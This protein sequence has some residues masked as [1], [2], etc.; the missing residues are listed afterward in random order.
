MKGL[1]LVLAPLLAL[2]IG[3]A[4]FAAYG[5]NPA[6]AYAAM[7]RA[8]LGSAHGLSECV[9]KATPLIFT[10]L[11][12][13]LPATMQ[14]WNIGAEGQFAW[15]AVAATWVALFAAPLLPGPLVLPAVFLAGAAAGAAWGAIPGALKARLG[16]SEILTTLL[17]NYVAIIAMEH[18]FFGPWRDPNGLGFPG[19]ALFP[20][21]AL[22]PR[23]PGARIH[24][25]LPLSLGL[26]LVLHLVLSRS[27]FGYRVRAMGLAPRAARYAGLDV[28]GHTLLV[29]ALAGGLAGLAGACEVTG[30]HHKLQEGVAVG[31][32][33]DGI[34]AA[35]LAR[36]KPAAVPLAALALGA[37]MVGGEGLQSALGLPASISQVLT[38][39]LLLGLLAADR[40]AARLEAAAAAREAEHAG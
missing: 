5:A 17:L 14:L 25:G 40:L 16:A 18:L 28:A 31:L 15:G 13:A 27:A 8:A 20:D 19:T 33:Y 3:A 34:V 12:V 30:I 4:V 35:C 6:E 32:G 11:A 10:G 7:A 39:S 29:L 9:V 21:A 24:L 36:L 38:A 2:A 22:N 26:A 37:V 23:L 1:S